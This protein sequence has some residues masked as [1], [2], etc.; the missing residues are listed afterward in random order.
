M[1]NT[2]MKTI[3]RTRYSILL[4]LSLSKTALFSQSVNVPLDHWVYEF[5]DR[6]Q[7]RGYIQN[8]MTSSR[9][10]SRENIAIMLAEVDKR[11][12]SNEIQLSMTE[13]AIFEQ[14]KGEFAEELKSQNITAQERYYER[15][16]IKWHEE[17]NQVNIDF[18]FNQSIDFKSG[19]QY[20]NREKISQTTVGT[21]ARGQFEDRLGFYLLVKNTLIKGKDIDQEN[22]DP[23]R[24]VPITISGKN[25]YT[26][27]ASAYFIWS[28]PRFHLELGRDQAQWGP[29]Y[30]GQLMISANNPYFDMFKIN[31]QFKRFTFTYFHGKLNI[32][33]SSKFIA[34]HRLELRLSPRFIVSGNESVIYGN[35]NVEPM[36][37]NPLMLY[38]IAEH[39]LGDRDN[40]T[41][42]LDIIAFPRIN[43]QLYF[44][45]FIDD[46]TTAENP[47]TY[48]GNKFAFLTGWHWINPFRVKDTNFHFE[49]TRIEPFVY[50]HKEN[51]NIYTNYD[52]SI[53][54]WLGPN[55]DDLFFKIDYLMKRDL[56]F[57]FITERIRHGE[58][59]INT[60][61]QDSMG[62][63]KKFLSGITETTWNLG[64][65]MR[66]QIF[67]DGFLSCSYYHLDIKNNSHILNQQA[68]NNNINLKLF[69]NY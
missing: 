49:Y 38:H 10:F 69:I 68:T 61:H 40:K 50:T 18:L 8:G 66:Y 32:G 17:N 3:K 30:R 53:G 35:R 15:H 29:G 4:F 43:H 65:E 13:T 2:T 34:A 51:I 5:V 28:F 64:I 23:A 27:D 67:R 39:H 11:M 20:E 58:G 56:K 41:M 24:G 37:I 55:A 6:M 47:W 57:A 21:I 62:T 63:R 31:V 44:E 25:A 42:G 46:F 52:Q 26:D 60:P 54:H 7:I 22:F 14:L 9:P 33:T 59:D 36:Y 1:N 48:Y 12:E 16:M 19:N 45:L